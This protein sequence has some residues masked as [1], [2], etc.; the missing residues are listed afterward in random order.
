MFQEDRMD[1]QKQPGGLPR[2]YYIVALVTLMVLTVAGGLIGYRIASVSLLDQTK[3]EHRALA[4]KLKGLDPAGM[5]QPVQSAMA[6]SSL[7]KVRFLDEND[8]IVYSSA[9]S[10][11][12]ST[13]LPEGNR[14]NWYY[15]DF[16][17][18]KHYNA[19]ETGG[20]TLA[21]RE[22][23]LTSVTVE[24][25]TGKEKSI[26]LYR[27]LELYTDVT[28][29]LQN[30]LLIDGGIAGGLGLIELIALAWVLLRK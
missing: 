22:V 18:I 16:T 13:A 29:S 23:V 26:I 12:G 6:A 21:N 28:A 25:Q 11:I 17:E 19:L 5:D 10:E 8:K 4:G 3:E 1:A 27:H 24:Q 30:I 2:Y 14:D 7:I 20:E 15:G 9:A